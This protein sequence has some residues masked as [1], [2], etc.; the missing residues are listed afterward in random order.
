MSKYSNDLQRIKGLVLHLRTLGISEYVRTHKSI[1]INDRLKMVF[2]RLLLDF[3]NVLNSYDRPNGTMEYWYFN[4]LIRDLECCIEY[5]RHA[6]TFEVE[7]PKYYF[8]TITETFRD[9][10]ATNLI[11]QFEEYITI[12]KSLD[13]FKDMENIRQAKFAVFLN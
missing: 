10:K 8:W 2:G 13:A 9:E 3:L 4:T 5:L 1:W 6:E 11:L 7:K 12:I